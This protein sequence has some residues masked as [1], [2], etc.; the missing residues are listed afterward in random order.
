MTFTDYLGFASMVL[1][2]IGAFN[3][4]TVAIRYAAG[5]LPTLTHTEMHALVNSNA[6]GQDFYEQFKT[7]DLLDLLNATAMVQMVIYWCVAAAGII[8]I[9]LFIWNSVEV[10]TTA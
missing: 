7:P 4:M 9:G 1:L 8:Y 6:T 2:L 3:W 10:K 5:D